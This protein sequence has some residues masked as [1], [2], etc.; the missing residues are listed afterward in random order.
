MGNNEGSDGAVHPLTPEQ[1]NHQSAR[2]AA[3]VEMNLEIAPVIQTRA[4][5][6]VGET[7][8]LIRN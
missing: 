4:R 5:P 1:T 8:G 6:G 2:D 3:A 7:E